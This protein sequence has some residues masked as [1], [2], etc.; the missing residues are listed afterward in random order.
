MADPNAA[1][2]QESAGQDRGAREGDRHSH[3]SHA[4]P[5]SHADG[6]HSGDGDSQD[7][8]GKHDSGHTDHS[9][10]EIMFRN[11]FWVNLGLSLPVLIFSP[12]IQDWLGYTV[13]TFPGS[14]WIVPVLSV[15]IFVYGGFPFLR[16]AWDE[17]KDRQPGMMTLISLA[18]SVAFVYSM[19]SLLANLG[20]S[21]FWELV[22]LI[23]VMLLGHWIEM[24]SVR[25]ASGSLDELAKL[26]P[27]T[28][29]R[30]VGDADATGDDADWDT[31]K[32][33]V[34]ELNAG[35]ILLVRPGAG[36]PADGDVIKGH[37]ELD[38]SMISGESKLVDK[39]PDDQVIA[40]TVN[41][42]SGS[43]RVRVT[44][45]GDETA[46]SGIMRLVKEAR[47]SKSH[48]QLLADRAAGWLFYAALAAALLT[49]VAWGLAV[50]FN[51]Q[52]LRRVITVLVIACPHALGLA[53]PLVVAIT[54]SMA[55][56]N[57][58]LVRDRLALESARQLDTVIFDKTGTLT[59]GEQGMVD[60]VTA[61]G[62][63]ADD[64]LA[65]VAGIE[66]DSEHMIARALLA[67]AKEKELDRPSVQEFEAI[68]GRGVQAQYEGRTVYVG[69][70]S[71]LESLEISLPEKLADFGDAAGDK[72]QTVVYL[73]RDEGVA[74]AFA[75]ADVIRPE[76]Q[77]AVRDLQSMGLEVAL[78]TGDSQDV[79]D[80][81]ARELNI[82][83]VFARVLPEDKDGKV[84]EL[85]DQGK[86][87]AMV[88]DGVN[89]APALTR[90]DVG[91]AIGSGTDVAVESAGLILVKS[92]PRDVAK[93][94]KLSR[95]SHTKMVQ[96]IWYAAGYNILAIPLA[97]G[98]MAPIGFVLPPAVGALIMS[99]STVVVAINAQLLRRAELET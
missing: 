30:I 2:S 43:L 63:Q 38:E 14:Q 37:S 8:H 61:D 19:A 18:I 55:A 59:K 15:A 40:G 36:V 53:V 6:R 60:M 69:G 42:G 76:S 13:P 91:I 10:H 23:D 34:G 17:L 26:L 65:L 52:T 20:D 39:G 95:A 78:L 97:A 32:V 74:A 31:E 77:Q 94:L 11:R 92:D 44:A 33:P 41:E 96:N 16:M 27:D 54:T 67:A 49:A 7:A 50:G 80:A 62:V 3:A 47:E 21:F 9:G 75:L 51:G 56:N 46:L 29:E 72:G 24:R 71:L 89:D 84:K 64:A 98:V 22:T 28:A 48:T 90:A 81:V 68:K 86:K 88:G 12:T 93:I 79:A 83:R 4:Q 45:I 66:G 35:D 25:Q 82:D 58:I 57:G 1:Q 85:Q 87:V 73:V 70:P 99:I 5:E